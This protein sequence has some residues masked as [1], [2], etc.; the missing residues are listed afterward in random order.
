MKNWGMDGVSPACAYENIRKIPNQIL[1]PTNKV[2][3][4]HNYQDKAEAKFKKQVIVANKLM[5]LLEK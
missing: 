3:L 5:E 4:W 2:T 1:I